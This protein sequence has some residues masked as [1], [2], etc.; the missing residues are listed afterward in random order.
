[1]NR[2]L[3][4][5]GIWA[6]LSFLMFGCSTGNMKVN[7]VHYFKVGYGDHANFYRLTV[8]ADTTLGIAEFRSG[9]FPS[10]SVDSLF[11]DVS[12]DG[13]V[14]ALRFRTD[15]EGLMETNVLKTTKAYLDAASDPDTEL[16]KLR[17][18]AEARRRVLAYPRSSGL[19]P[20]EY[21]E[22][23]Y[24]PARGIVKRHGDEKMVFIISSNPDEV[25]VKIASFSES[26]ASS[27][28]IQNL[29][30]VIHQQ[31]AN[32][33]LAKEGAAEA[34]RKLDA[35]LVTQLTNSINSIT[36]RDVSKDAAIQK[37]DIILNLI[38]ALP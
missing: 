34:T 5:L 22:V 3:F 4:S 23:D 25:V 36:N 2:I 28:T 16:V 13:G 17:K 35:L 38:N 31:V 10:R 24:D 14:S 21:S 18:L 15:M 33:L 37:I 1:M 20:D 32:D 6:L 29:G 26:S 19:K 11:G 27:L 8:D 30:R 9:W 7:E 12:S